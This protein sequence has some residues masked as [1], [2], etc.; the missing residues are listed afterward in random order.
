MPNS[1]K[2]FR[3]KNLES[4]DRMQ[5]INSLRSTH[6]ASRAPVSFRSYKQQELISFTSPEPVEVEFLSFSTG[7]GADGDWIFNE[8][9]GE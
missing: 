8:N 4:L 2:Y 3:V 1:G 9:T 5:L 6:M 7:W